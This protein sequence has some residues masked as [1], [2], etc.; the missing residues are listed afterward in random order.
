MSFPGPPDDLEGS[1]YDLES[2][3]SGSGDWSEPVEIKDTVSKDGTK[4]TFDGTSDLNKDFGSE[5]IFVESSKSFL[6]N[7]DIFAAVIAGGAI[8][9]ALA[10]ALAT[11]LIYT[12][13]HKDNEGYILAQQTAS[14]GDYHRPNREE[15]I[16]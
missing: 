15:V 9:V 6:E 3:G 14:G 13:Q 8:G 1:G 5:F 12:W 4:S 7:K 16:V 11:I 10:A 2:S